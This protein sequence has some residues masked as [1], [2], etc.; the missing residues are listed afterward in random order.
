MTIRKLCL[1]LSVATVPM[2][3][4]ADDGAASIAGGGIILMKSEPRIVMAK[5]VLQ[6]SRSKVTVDYDFRNDSDQD[7]TTT[8]AFPIP[9][10]RMTVDWRSNQGFDDFRLWVNGEASEFRTEARA[11][12]GEKEYTKLLTSLR[13]DVGSFGHSTDYDQSSDV[14]RLGANDR[15]Q[16]VRLGLIDPDYD[17]QPNKNGAPNWRVAK[18]Y[19]WEQTFPSHKTVH[20]RHEYSPVLGYTGSLRL[21]WGTNFN[22]EW[23][24]AEMKSFCVDSGLRDV[25]QRMVSSKEG[26]A[27]YEYVD[28]ILTTANT[29][30]KPIE[31][32]TLIVERPH[33]KYDGDRDDITGYVSFCWDGSVQKVDT[34]HFLAHAVNFVPTK[35][36]KIGFFWNQNPHR[37]K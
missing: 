6:I 13:V 35:E 14:Q 9:D 3:L 10:Y 31:D 22:N 2:N 8:I 32:F 34:D 21:G 36:L 28:F 30:K 26:D 18:K 37:R 19:Y 1:L 15:Q 29:W 17:R 4:N 16:L 27:P 5:E 12:L 33:N 20:I 24:I 7:V 25:L 11:F 23:A